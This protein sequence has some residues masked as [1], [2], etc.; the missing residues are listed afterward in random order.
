MFGSKGL[1]KGFLDNTNSSQKKGD[2]RKESQTASDKPKSLNVIQKAADTQTNLSQDK[3]QQTKVGSSSREVIKTLEHAVKDKAQHSDMGSSYDSSKNVDIP[4]NFERI[5]GST[6]LA[7]ADIIL[8]GHVH[9]P[10]YHQA[11]IEFINGYAKKGDIFLV[12]GVQAGQ[13]VKKRIYEELA[14]RVFKVDIPLIKG[15][16]IYGCDDMVTY[17][18]QLNLVGSSEYETMRD[19]LNE[20]RNNKILEAINENRNN[21]SDKRIFVTTGINHFTESRIQ[22]NLGSQRYIALIPK[23]KL[24]EKDREASTFSYALHGVR[25]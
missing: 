18:E 2:G 8:L 15:I 5:G 24:T 21:S 19:K 17:R 22:E 16:K 10:R 7:N 23:Y 4:A 25:L 1:K 11:I 13:K 20:I 14:K 6:D 12:E 3:A 9:T